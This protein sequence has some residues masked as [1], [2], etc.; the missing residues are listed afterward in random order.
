MKRLLAAFAASATALW[1]R[2]VAA[3]PVVT[4]AH[5]IVNAPCADEAAFWKRVGAHTSLVTKASAGEVA[6]TLVVAVHVDD[7]RA[8]GSFGVH[9]GPDAPSS[10]ERSVSGKTC[11]EVVDALSF[12]VA[13]TYDPDA[14]DVPL[15]SAPPPLPR[16]WPRADSPPAERSWSL[17]L[18]A[19]AELAAMGEIPV[20]GLVFAQASRRFGR[21]EP[22]FRISFSALTTR[23]QTSNVSARFVWLSTAPE[24]CLTRFAAGVWS[25]SPCGSVRIGV[26]SATPS[27]VPGG[28]SFTQPWL[29]PR[30]LVRGAVTLDRRLSIELSCGIEAPLLRGR[31]VFGPVPAYRIPAIAPF[32]MLGLSLGIGS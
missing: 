23:V 13:L 24:A 1:A 3:Q 22:A 9:E 28:R 14:L 15:R 21:I 20:G 25:L 5:A 6:V 10:Y 26:S 4:R 32:A 29:A 27:G 2:N 30:V 11:E 16:Q 8:T 17:A 12:F 19:A 18:G 31:Y 7:E